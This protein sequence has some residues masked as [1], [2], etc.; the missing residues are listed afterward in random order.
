MNKVFDAVAAGDRMITAVRASLDADGRTD[1]TL[2]RDWLT[3]TADTVDCFDAVLAVPIDRN[4]VLRLI[5]DTSGNPQEFELEKFTKDLINALPNVE[6]ARRSLRRYMADIRRAA[7]TAI[8]RAHGEGFNVTLVAVNLRATYA[9]NMGRR[10]WT[11]AAS[12]VL[13]TVVMNRVNQ[14]LEPDVIEFD[15]EE[16]EHV[17]GEMVRALDLWE[18]YQDKDNAP[19]Q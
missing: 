1:I 13:A 17:A 6:K 5:S 14:H 8:D 2:D 12:F 4:L 10:S 19:Q 18:E 9:G 3:I 15:V 7:K 11:E 16:P